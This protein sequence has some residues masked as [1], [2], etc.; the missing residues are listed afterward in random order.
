MIPIKRHRVSNLKLA[1]ISSV[2]HPAQ[3]GARAVLIKSAVESPMTDIEIRKNASAVASGAQPAYSASTF[4]DA[5]LRRAEELSVR[6]NVTPEQALAKNLSSD[7]PLMDLAH[8]AE[9]ARCAA[10]GAEVRKR[11]GERV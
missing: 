9:I 8:A 11:Q 1:E 3:I 6:Q 5:M 10:Y 4:E 7:T 2:D